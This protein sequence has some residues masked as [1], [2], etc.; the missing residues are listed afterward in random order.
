MTAA[1]AVALPDT[2]DSSSVVVLACLG[3]LL[4]GAAAFALVHWSRE[5]P[6]PH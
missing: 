2:S 6:H 5:E 3:L 4:C 1:S